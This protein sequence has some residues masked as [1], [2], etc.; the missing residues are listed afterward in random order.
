MGGA[1]L[2]CMH[3]NNIIVIIIVQQHVRVELVVATFLSKLMSLIL[4]QSNRPI[5]DK[6]TTQ[7]TACEYV[8]YHNSLIMLSTNHSSFLEAVAVNEDQQNY[9]IFVQNLLSDH[10]IC[11]RLPA[12]PS[13]RVQ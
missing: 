11:T 2:S 9:L 6:L 10:P 3:T 1:A 5:Y 12:C 8:L 7:S 13:D 4:W